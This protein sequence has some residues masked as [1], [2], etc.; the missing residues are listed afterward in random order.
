MRFYRITTPSN[1]RLKFHCQFQCLK[2]EIVTIYHTPNDRIQLALSLF[3]VGIL[4]M[5]TR[6]PFEIRGRRCI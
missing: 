4:V 1:V 6:I 3:C 5:S 2:K